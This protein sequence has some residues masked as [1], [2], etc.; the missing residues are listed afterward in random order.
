MSDEINDVNPDELIRLIDDAK[1][2]AQD[3][4]NAANEMQQRQQEKAGDRTIPLDDVIHGEE[5][6]DAEEIVRKLDKASRLLS[7][8]NLTGKVPS[9]KR[10]NRFPP[11]LMKPSLTLRI[12]RRFMTLRTM[13]T[14]SMT[15]PDH[16]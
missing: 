12:C 11:S 14:A 13:R 8:F 16:V 15:N 4:I 6:I 10:C 7:N 5:K 9:R 2:Q 3:F 1:E